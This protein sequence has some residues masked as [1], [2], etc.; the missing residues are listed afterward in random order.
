M[1]NGKWQSARATQFFITFKWLEII[2]V[3]NRVYQI[4]SNQP[5]EHSRII[6]YC[7]EKSLVKNIWIFVPKI[8]AFFHER[9][10]K[11]WIWIFSSKCNVCFAFKN[12]QS[13]KVEF[14]T[15]IRNVCFD[16]AKLS[17]YFHEKMAIFKSRI[18]PRQ[19][20][21]FYFWRTNSSTFLTIF[22]QYETFGE[23]FFGKF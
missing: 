3:I 5:F 21:M 2:F 13:L 11:L 23:T 8:V 22:W 9:K 12:C 20:E 4:M 18:F 15:S 6:H 10:R 7:G 16:F 17:R 19:I 14:F 1:T